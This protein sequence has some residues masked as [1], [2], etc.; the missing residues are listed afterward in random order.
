[1]LFD[2]AVPL[3]ADE[4]CS[5]MVEAGHDEAVEPQSVMVAKV[6]DSTVWVTSA[7]TI[8]A[9]AAIKATVENCIFNVVVI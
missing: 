2:G 3:A 1:M 7:E 4:D 6:V 5:A 9:V 8:A